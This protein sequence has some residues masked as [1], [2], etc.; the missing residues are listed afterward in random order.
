MLK[1]RM[2]VAWPMAVMLASV[3]LVVIRSVIPNMRTSAIVLKIVKNK[4]GI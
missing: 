2:L 4:I 1:V 3:S